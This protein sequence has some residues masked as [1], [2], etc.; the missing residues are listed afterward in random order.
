MGGELY[1]NLSH[2][3]K[4]QEGTLA[5]SNQVFVFFSVWEIKC[6]RPKILIK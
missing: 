6:F 2:I 4:C 5:L 3:L 1:M